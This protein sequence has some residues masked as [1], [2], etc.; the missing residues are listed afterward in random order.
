MDLTEF[1]PSTDRG[2][3]Y[4]HRDVWNDLETNYTRLI[5]DF[6]QAGWYPLWFSQVAEEAGRD[7]VAW[8]YYNLAAAREP[9]N[10][11]LLSKIR[12]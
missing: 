6:P 8:H 1:T 2:A 12:R 10:A 4:S 5:E 3:Y 9:N 7:S 11:R